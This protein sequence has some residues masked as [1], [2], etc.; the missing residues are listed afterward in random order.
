MVALEDVARCRAPD[1]VGQF[2]QFAL[3]AGLA[4]ARVLA[5]HAQDEGFELPS[6]PQSPS[7]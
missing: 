2:G 6:D 3:D 7:P 4:P 1:G 5:S